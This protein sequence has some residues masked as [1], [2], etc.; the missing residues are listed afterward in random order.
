MLHGHVY[1]QYTLMYVHRI[2]FQS[3]FLFL[4]RTI[5][6]ISYYSLLQKILLLTTKTQRKR[7]TLTSILDQLAMVLSHCHNYLNQDG[8]HLPT[9]MSSRYSIIVLGCVILLCFII[10]RNVTSPKSHLKH[11]KQLLSSYPH[12]QD[13]N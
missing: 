5:T 13:C 4:V 11:P 10:I 8:I 2:K 3:Y 1:L 12:S 9:L 7:K 6:F